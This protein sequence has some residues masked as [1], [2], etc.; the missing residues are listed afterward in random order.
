[1]DILKSMHVYH[2]ISLFKDIV[3]CIFEYPKNNVEFRIYI[4]SFTDIHN[5]L[6]GYPYFEFRVSL[7]G[8]ILIGYIH[9]SNEGYIKSIFETFSYF[10]NF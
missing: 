5:Q 1:M 9:Y 2:K 3:K 10:S 8:L 4:I 6:Y 7:K